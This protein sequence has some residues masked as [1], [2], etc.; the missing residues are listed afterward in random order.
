MGMVEGTEGYKLFPTVS[1][2]LSDKILDGCPKP[3]GSAQSD[4]LIRHFLF[5]NYKFKH[6]KNQ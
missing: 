5:G 2:Y 6:A 4:S 3:V 1:F